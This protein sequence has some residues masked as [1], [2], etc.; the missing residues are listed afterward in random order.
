MRFLPP[1]IDNALMFEV[2]NRQVPSRGVEIRLDTHRRRPLGTVLPNL[3]KQVLNKL[4][5]DLRGV[6]VLLDES[7][8]WFRIGAKQLLKG[9]AVSTLDAI[10]PLLVP[11]GVRHNKPP[12]VNTA[13]SEP[14]GVQREGL[15]P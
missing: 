14:V 1:L 10:R 13:N 7:T 3:E 2:V 15:K 12:S 11:L 9:G 6:G 5:C 4:F 8:E